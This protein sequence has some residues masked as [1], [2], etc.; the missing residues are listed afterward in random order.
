MTLLLPALTGWATFVLALL[1]IVGLVTAGVLV[2]RSTIAH[3]AA[4][5]QAET[6]AAY[7]EKDQ[8][9]TEKVARLE[10]IITTIQIALKRQLKIEITIDD[11]IV[12]LT[13]TGVRKKTMVRVQRDA[14]LRGNTG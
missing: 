1:T 11:D 4:R 6:I 10:A 9:M 14:G 13:Q 3:E 12:T 5:L 2:V 8:V 7:K